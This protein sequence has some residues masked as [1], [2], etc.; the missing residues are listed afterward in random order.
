M[1]H[2]KEPLHGPSFSTYSPDDVLWLL[3]DISDA[4]LEAPKEEREEAIQ[5]GEA[6]YSESLPVEYQPP[7]EYMRVFYNALETQAQHMA[8]YIG[9]MTEQVLRA[10][11]KNVILVSLARAGVPVGILA[12]RWLSTVHNIDAP[13]YAVSIVRGRGIDTEALSYIAANHDPKDVV[14]IDGWTGKGAITRELINTLD[15]YFVET[16]VRFSAELAVLADTAGCANFYG[17]REDFLIP[18][19]C[20]NSTVSGLISRTVLN[21]D[22]IKP[23]MFHGAKFYKDLESTDV[24][25]FLLDKA[26]DLFNPE[27]AYRLDS[28]ITSEEDYGVNNWKGWDVVR[29]VAERFDIPTVNLVKPGIGETTRVLLRRVPWLILVNPDSP[30]PETLKH[31][32]MLAEERGVPLRVDRSITPYDCIGI[33][34]PEFDKTAT[35]DDG[36]SV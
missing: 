15:C 25:N 5:S 6:H 2:T 33:I 36:K 26:T 35:G 7:A 28:Q 9:A 19:A 24:S 29:E 16:G 3:T 20:L 11:G 22:L 34:N 32:V 21:F 12:K 27:Q 30:S 10:R 18:S 13:H 14:F 31:V 23:G 17:T 4:P 8:D 1:S